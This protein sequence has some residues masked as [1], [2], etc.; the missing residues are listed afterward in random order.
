MYT[1]MY[2]YVFICMQTDVYMYMD[3]F[4][5]LYVQTGIMNMYST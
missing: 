1:Y 5:Y 4:V 2:E 3:S